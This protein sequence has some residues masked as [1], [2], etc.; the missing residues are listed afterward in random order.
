MVAVANMLTAAL[1]GNPFNMLPTR[2]E[3]EWEACFQRWEHPASPSEEGMIDRA[4]R[5]VKAALDD[6]PWFAREGVT[7]DPQGSYFNNTNVR[8]QADMDIRVTH[9]SLVI[10][11]S[12]SVQEPVTNATFGYYDLPRTLQE[13]AGDLRTHVGE[14][15]STVFDNVIPGNR[16]FSIREVPGSRSDIDVVPAL[17]FHFIT[18][19]E[20]GDI[21][22][23]EGVCIFGRDGG[24]TY[25]F[26]GQHHTK[27]KLKRERTGH[28]FKKVVR[29]VKSLRDELVSGNVIGPKELPSF[30]IESLVYRVE[31][32]FFIQNETR[33][34]RV[35]RILKRIDQL[36]GDPAWIAYAAEI[37]DSKQLFMAEQS[38]N[39]QE[40]RACVKLCLLRLGA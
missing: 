12:P 9:P 8:Q 40:V 26:P 13:I 18:H 30:L 36:L 21:G 27:G 35:K 15:L 11:K 7:T 25:N 19:R 38:W 22:P 33:L 14:A 23:I 5:M 4:A 29:T 16:A 3:P 34:S 28:R 20:S 1:N 32:D 37:N 39:V 10:L 24:R 2:T 17:R 31:D 6:D